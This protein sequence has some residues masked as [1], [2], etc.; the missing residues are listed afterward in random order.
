MSCGRRRSFFVQRTRQTSKKEYRHNVQL[1][2]HNFMRCWGEKFE[3]FFS[4]SLL[5]CCPPS[6]GYSDENKEKTNF[7]LQGVLDN[8]PSRDRVKKMRKKSFPLRFLL[9]IARR[10]MESV[11]IFRFSCSKSLTTDFICASFSQNCSIV[12][13]QRRLERKKNSEFFWC[14]LE[15]FNFVVLLFA[16][17]QK[18]LILIPH[19]NRRLVLVDKLSL[20]LFA[21]KSAIQIEL[22]H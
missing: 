17:L 7:P 10:S 22:I 5:C 9:L 20:L 18:F 13:W 3:L 16:V 21:W 12:A 8:Y 1:N 14:S 11:V 2:L 6:P 4:S 19:S 15:C